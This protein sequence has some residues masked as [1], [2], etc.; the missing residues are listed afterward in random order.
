M[1]E[2][3]TA[4]AEV[5]AQQIKETGAI[6]AEAYSASEVLHGPLQL[7]T[8]PLVVLVLDTGA[9]STLG[10]VENAEA[11]LRAIGSEVHRIAPSCR[12]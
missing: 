6:H 1:K 10:S 3:G 8:N 9:P 11:R 5:L 4:A 7:A 2:P 12:G